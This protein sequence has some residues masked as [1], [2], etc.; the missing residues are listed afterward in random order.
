MADQVVRI[1]RAV[2]LRE[3]GLW[4]AVVAVWLAVVWVLWQRY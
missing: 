3:L 1:R 4:L 2:F